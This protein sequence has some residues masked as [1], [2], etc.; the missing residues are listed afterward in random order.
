MAWLSSYSK[1]GLRRQNPGW[2]GLWKRL[3]RVGHNLR[4]QTIFI[5]FSKLGRIE[6]TVSVVTV[7]LVCNDLA[8]A[9]SSM[10][11]HKQNQ[12]KSLSHIGL[13]GGIYFA[14]VLS[15]HLHEGM[16]AIQKI[17]HNRRLS[18]VVLRCGPRA[19]KA[20]NELCDCLAGGPEADDF[21]KYVGRIRNKIAFHY[22]PDFLRWAIR[23]R[24][25]RSASDTASLTAGEDIH[26][27]RF[28]FGDAL[29][30]SIVCRKLWGIPRSADL[31]IEAD[32]AA[33]WCHTKCVPFLEFGQE[34]VLR[35]LKEHGVLT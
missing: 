2:S 24:A 28:E 17:K 20:F 16:K 32:R 35:F 18:A 31:Q 3:R 33:N 4:T 22:D 1:G 34:F 19:R 5:S 7:A 14:R 25:S 29:L 15:G 27:T 11:R 23:D 12:F 8:I 21:R 10:G 26:S 13:G 9:N 6:G 30:D